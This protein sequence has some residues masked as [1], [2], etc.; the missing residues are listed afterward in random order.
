MAADSIPFAEFLVG[1]C[2]SSPYGDD[3]RVVLLALAQAAVELSEKISRGRLAGDMARPVEGSGGGDPQ[4]A[5][6]VF[7]NE[8]ILAALRVC[9][10]SWVASEESPNAIELNPEGSLALAIDPLDGSSN[11][12]TNSAIGTIFS[13]RPATLGAHSFFGQGI[14]QVAA[15]FAI[16]GPQTSI[17]FTVGKGTYMATLDRANKTFMVSPDRM[18]IHAPCCEYAINGSNE[19]HWPE[20][21]KNYVRDC[22]AGIHGPRGRD[23]NT[24]WIASLVA[25]AYRILVRGGVYLY[26][27]DNRN[28]YE[29]G[30]LRLVYE[31]FPIAMLIEQ[32]GGSATD[33]SARI[34]ERVASNIHSRTPLVFGSTQE[35]VRLAIYL[36]PRDYPPAAKAPLFAERGLFRA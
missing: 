31:A 2:A 26:P 12:D 11:I 33:G 19:R 28:G 3:I 22:Q 9:P 8:T 7:A 6:D 18:E 36:D 4:K 34:L 17:V 10:V 15:G 16:Y 21:V 32:A 23:F 13:L 35:V 5:L 27:A 20:G 24:R 14:E 29:Y 30:R 25:D 1:A